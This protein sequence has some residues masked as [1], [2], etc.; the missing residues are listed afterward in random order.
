MKTRAPASS[1][2]AKPVPARERVGEYHRR[3]MDAT[4][5][6]LAYAGE[7]VADW[8]RRLRRKLR[9]LLGAVPADRTPVRTTHLWTRPHRL[10][11]I[12]KILIH[13]GSDYAFPAY[14]CLPKAAEP[15]Y[16]FVICLQGHSTGMHKS[17]GVS[18]RSETRP[19]PSE[20]DRDF[21]IGCM[22]RGLAALCIE[23]RAF[24]ET[25]LHLDRSPSCK[26]PAMQAL[27]L[28]RTLLAER[29]HDVDRGIDYLESRPD[30]V[31]SRIAVMGNSGG[32]TTALFAAALL[33]RIAMAMPASCFCTFRE[34]ILAVRHCECN[35]VP[36]LWKYAEMSD[37]AGL[38]APRPLV[39]VNGRDD[40][41]FP[42]QGA[43]RAFRSLKTI[44]RACGAESRCHIVIGN[45]GHRFYA[46]DAWPVFLRYLRKSPEPSA[47]TAPGRRSSRVPLPG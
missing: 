5:Q 19:E 11:T 18:L 41:I 37:I 8:Q 9:Q 30:A 44:Y 27:M 14:V 35:Y 2:R 24:G 4:G 38:I 32:G 31:M 43:R 46:D 29:I 17:I 42:I 12:Q 28:G 26:L 39:L 7:N 34:S 6:R 45:G 15:P 1:R 10:G 3:L 25:S 16:Q 21:A 40:T 36:N 20:G 13:S 47:K 33:P 22:S 23:Q